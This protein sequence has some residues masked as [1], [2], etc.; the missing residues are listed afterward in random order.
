[1]MF[2]VADIYRQVSGFRKIAEKSAHAQTVATRLSF[3]SPSP[4]LRAWREANVHTDCMLLRF[5]T[6]ICEFVFFRNSSVHSTY[7]CI[8]QMMSFIH[9][10]N[11]GVYSV[12][13]ASSSEDGLGRLG[14][15]DLSLKDE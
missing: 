9:N 2:S 5:F 1:M 15:S 11:N 3:P 10:V 4:F 7:K 14:F 13:I 8:I 12:P 6:E